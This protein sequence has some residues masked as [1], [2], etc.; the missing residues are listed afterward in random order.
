MDNILITGGTSHLGSSI[1]KYFS[2]K[3]YN[4]LVTSRRENNNFK[5]GIKCISDIDLLETSCLTTLKNTVSEKF[6]SKFTLINTVGF[7][8]EN[9]HQPFLSHS[10]DELN[11][12]I[13]NNYIALSNTLH[14]LLPLMIEK[15]GGNI[16]SISCKSVKHNF[17][18]MI[19]FTAS[20][21]AVESLMKGIANEYS[22][23]GIVSNTL[24]LATLQTETE[25]NLKPHGDYNNWLDTKEVAKTI[26]T[27][28]SND[29]SYIN[30][31]VIE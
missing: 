19:P 11:K 20:K 7:F 25:Q 9:G 18:W 22:K 15:G 30:G 10:L 24:E 29:N 8:P 13:H 28:I 4:V 17:P 14:Y 1:A 5:S 23:E 16:I 26:H 12:I 31:N 2:N 6:D 21:A 27:L 3:G